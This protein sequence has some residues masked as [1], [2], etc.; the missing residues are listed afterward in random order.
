LQ[1]L[2]WQT[3]TFSAGTRS[4]RRSTARIRDVTAMTPPAPNAQS[5]SPW[6]CSNITPSVD[7]TAQT[8][9]VNLAAFLATVFIVDCSSRPRISLHR[10]GVKLLSLRT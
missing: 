7:T 2:H 6:Q 1:K 4:V 10:E 8:C 9:I 5:P 3:R